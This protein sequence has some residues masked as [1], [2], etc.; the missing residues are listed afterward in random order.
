MIHYPTENAGM[1]MQ[2]V[3]HCYS[4]HVVNKVVSTHKNYLHMYKRVRI[5]KSCFIL[6]G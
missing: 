4:L 2:G 6:V 5:E 1:G 3:K